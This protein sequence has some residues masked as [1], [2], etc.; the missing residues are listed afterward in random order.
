[1]SVPGSGLPSLQTTVP[2]YGLSR[3]LQTIVPGGCHGPLVSQ[4][5][6]PGLL[7]PT[8]RLVRQLPSS[9]PVCPS[10]LTQTALLPG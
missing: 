2:A 10:I 3:A 8:P 4:W 9:H 5:A 7:T 1:M 6:S